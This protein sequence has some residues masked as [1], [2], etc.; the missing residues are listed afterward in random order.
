MKTQTLLDKNSFSYCKREIRYSS[1]IDI[2][3]LLF[4]FFAICF[5]PT[6]AQTPQRI[7]SI[8]GITEYRLNNGLKVLL[9]PDASK[10]TITVNITYLVGSR[11]EGYGESGMAHLLEHMLFKGSQRHKNIPQEL[12]AHGCRSNG[13]TWYD[14]TNY[15][16]TFTASDENLR[17]VL[18]LESDRMVNSFIDKKDL[19]TEFSVVRNEFEAS[20]NYAF[21]VL[22]ERVFSTAFLWHNYGKSTIGSKEDIERVP[23]ENLQAFYKKY[24]Q[25][26]NA[27]L[28]IAGKI[29]EEQTLQ[30]VVE[31][32]GAI[33]K[34][35]RTLTETYTVEPAQD[36]ER[37]VT[38]KRTGDVQI[39]SCGYHIPAATHPDYAGIE[40]ISEMLT[41]KPSGRLYKALVESGKSST[42]Y[43]SVY[44]LK[45]PGYVYFESEALKDK[46]L[47]DVGAEM[48]SLLDSLPLH[49]FTAEEVEQARTTLLKEV[50]E[51]YTNTD[52][53]CM[54]LSEYI[55]LGDWRHWFLYR[56]RLE[57]I[58]VEEVN[59]VVAR[60]FISSNRTT[61]Y[62]I[63][64]KLPKRVQVPDAPVLEEELKKYEGRKA[65]SNLETFD[66]SPE[67]IQRNI[68]AGNFDG[69]AKYN[70]LSKPNRGG[71]VNLSISLRI[72]NQ[73]ALKN[74]SIV[75]SLTLA[76]LKKGS[77]HLSYE[78]LND[79][80]DKMNAN[81]FIYG[82][83][84]QV[85]L[86][87]NAEKKYLKA[88][89]GLLEE[90]L[91]RPVFPESEL[92]ILKTE[93]ITA[94]EELKSDP[95]ALVYR[96]YSKLTEN[97]KPSDFRYT[98]DFEDQVAAIKSISREDL[99]GFYKD[100]YNSSNANIS[101]VGEFDE[102]ELVE[103][104]K[105]IFSN[106]ES[107]VVY[108]RAKDEF[109]PGKQVSE[110]IA[111]P[112]KKNAMLLGGMKL[113]VNDTHEEYPALFMANYIFGGGFLNS[114][115][116]E[117]L[118]QEEGL[119]YGS[120][121]ILY[122]NSLDSVSHFRL[123]AMFN[124]ENL[125]KVKVACN[126]ELDR[127]IKNGVTESELKDAVN[128]Y[129][130]SRMLSRS[131]DNELSSKMSSYMQIER[132]IIW[133]SDFEAK[134]A[135]LKVNQVNATI[136]KWI[137]TEALVTVAAGDF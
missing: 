82:S 90:I 39:V 33:P 44:G 86:I 88:T 20:E 137:N 68:R 84:Q 62:F 75:A 63:P 31:Y 40:I 118:R 46:K 8:E 19:A 15:Y 24:Y 23:I 74:K 116:A 130:Q 64:E 103:G 96:K 50:E 28:I 55:A 117:R 54:T 32:F 113:P 41:D 129:L 109:I 35:A 132:N 59:Q 134:V 4:L 16:E 51:Q 119:S 124:P 52:Y 22:Q 65:L 72:G 106:W 125:E 76:M 114:R 115:L 9:F 123:Y 57:Q 83:G 81:I 121:S 89:L 42:C 78:Q 107:P 30:M 102:K 66:P 12:T 104:L 93:R 25:P 45:E 58:K 110:K 98:M 29:E 73:E 127:F 61:G 49:P 69:G 80:L 13:T 70:L 108:E 87:A 14:R 133:D 85:M 79:S 101:C 60:Y 43:G 111:T 77:K 120:G 105:P 3:I 27:V 97:Y 99:T 1:L 38:L 122:G 91:R 136:A 126:E 26:D 56:D 34:S 17:W 53:L 11:H 95:I 92:E 112:D 131:Q 67:N 135:A 6:I 36:G 94:I 100:F 10:P 5:L 37:H 71:K 2:R 47:V 128:G 18:D 48:F 21:A 7:S